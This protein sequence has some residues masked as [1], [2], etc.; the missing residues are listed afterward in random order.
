MTTEVPTPD[1]RALFRELPIAVD[2]LM[3]HDAHC[4]REVAHMFECALFSLQAVNPVR[5]WDEIVP[6]IGR[7]AIYARDAHGERLPQD[8]RDFLDQVENAFAEWNHSTDEPE[9]VIRA[10]STPRSGDHET[11]N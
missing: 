3:S 9:D 8:T 5:A 11:A 1:W 2:Q 6:M 10:L 7:L 4:S